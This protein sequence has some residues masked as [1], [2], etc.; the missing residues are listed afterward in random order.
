MKNYVKNEIPDLTRL[1]TLAAILRILYTYKVFIH[2]NNN[3]NHISYTTLCPNSPRFTL[4]L[5]KS[6][7]FYRLLKVLQNT[8]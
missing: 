7:L 2:D 6:V 3:M 8:K 4:L 1:L 5:K